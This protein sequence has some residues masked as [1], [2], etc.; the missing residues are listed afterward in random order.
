MEF[1]ALD[2]QSFSVV[3]DVGFRRLV[4]HLEHQ[5]TLPSRRY[6]SDVALAELQSI[7]EA[8]IHALLAT[9]IASLTFRPA[10]SAP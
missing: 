10:M 3:N 2:N 4:Q 5:D 9:V 1:I 6:F 7:V 8:Y